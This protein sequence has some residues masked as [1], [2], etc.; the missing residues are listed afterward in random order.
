MFV[1]FS[2]AFTPLLA[3]FYT[4]AKKIESTSFELVF[5]S[6]D[7]DE[8]SFLQYFK[9]MPWLALPFND[10]LLKSNLGA[11]FNVR[12]I[13]CLI[14]LDANGNIKDLD[15]RTTVGRA[16]GNVA[17][18]LCEWAAAEVITE[19]AMKKKQG[20]SSFPTI[21][22]VIIFLLVWWYFIK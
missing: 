19:E 1:L 14:I 6:S 11:K 16:N 13:P 8:N 3:K 2:R 17:K 15:G 4:D 22:I 5:C 7:S 21:L 12:G 20:G 9:S 10:R 18:A